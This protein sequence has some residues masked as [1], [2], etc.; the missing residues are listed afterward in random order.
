M[1]GEVRLH[2]RAIL[3]ALEAI[4][5]VAFE[6][7]VWRVTSF[8]RDALRGGS[9]NGRWS[10]AGEFEVLYTSLVRN[11]ALSEIGYRLSL[12][13]IWP[14]RLQHE[15]HTIEVKTTRTLRFADVNSLSGL[16]VDITQYE[17]FSYQATRAIAA[18]AHF[19]EFDGLLVPSARAEC[20]NLVLFLDRLGEGSRLE[21]LKSEPIDWD[22][23][24]NS[25]R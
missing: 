20:A 4:D 11:S 7:P 17:S 6:G 2:D 16:G 10:P 15:I 5:P 12:E 22:N 23:W 8:G 25:Q 13:P 24:R 19:L 1:A 18:A 9:A 14:S 3:D 21:V